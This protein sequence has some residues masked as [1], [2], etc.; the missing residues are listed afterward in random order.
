MAK[1]QCPTPSLLWG[2]LCSSHKDSTHVPQTSQKQPTSE[3][4]HVLSPMPEAP[5]LKSFWPLL[6]CHLPRNSPTLTSPISPVCM[7]HQLASK[8][9]WSMYVF[10]P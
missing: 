10:T 7:L 2:F 1:H 5:F 8:I 4:L 6:K 9:S 3:S